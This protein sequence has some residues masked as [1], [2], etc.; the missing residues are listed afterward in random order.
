M[1]LFTEL[2]AAHDTHVRF[3]GQR[4]LLDLLLS[5]LDHIS[6]G[7]TAQVEI[8]ICVLLLLL[9]RE[10][11]RHAVDIGA[12]GNVH[13][14]VGPLIPATLVGLPLSGRLVDRLCKWHVSPHVL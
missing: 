4:Q 9:C 12:A 1:L 11:D 10:R 3:R 5:L 7:T 8:W 13:L 2:D 14:H 6:R